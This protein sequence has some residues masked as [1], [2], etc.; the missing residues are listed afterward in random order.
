MDPARFPD[1]TERR[2][3]LEVR[4]AG[5]RL[6]GYAAVFDSEAPIGAFRESI[7]PGAFRAALATGKDVLAL[8]DHDPARLLGRT[9]SGTLRLSED[10]RGLAFELDVPDTQLGRDILALACQSAWKRPPRSAS[11]RDPGLA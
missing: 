5:R 10:S 11:K 3:A 1:G 4:A 8:V 9:G 6:E 2:A 7:R